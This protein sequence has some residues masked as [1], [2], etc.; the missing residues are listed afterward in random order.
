L[1]GNTLLE[2][3]SILESGN[4]KLAIIGDSFT[5]HYTNTF[6]EIIVKSLNLSLVDHIGFPGGSQY[7]LYKNFLSQIKNKPNIILCVHTESS[8]IYHNKL[9]INHSTV[10]HKL[11]SKSPINREI[12][13]AADQYYKYLHN[14]ELTDFIN[15]LIIREMQIICKVNNIKM[16][17][18]PAFNYDYIDKYYGLWLLLKPDGL[19]S[20]AHKNKSYLFLKNHFDKD[21]HE[22]LAKIFIPYIKD[23]I[24]TNTNKNILIDI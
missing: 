20:Q 22:I 19:S 24:N 10:K 13:L 3:K 16:V 18:I 8:R 11:A 9:T 12:Y 6:L 4:L 15:N 21:N 17:N 7:Q 14:Y 5:E 2:R 1:L 23:Y